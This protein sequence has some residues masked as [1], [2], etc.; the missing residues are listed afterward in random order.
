MKVYTSICMIQVYSLSQTRA[1]NL[2]NEVQY[3]VTVSEGSIEDGFYYTV[4]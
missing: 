3:T 1:S 2:R 4:I